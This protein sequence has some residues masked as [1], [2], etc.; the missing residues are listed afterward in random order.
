MKECHDRENAAAANKKVND[1]YP[2]IVRFHENELLSYFDSLNGDYLI[3]RKRKLNAVQTREQALAYIGGARSSFGECLGE[4][5]VGGEVRAD[6]VKSL[7]KGQYRID[8]VL[9]ES[10]PGYYL[11]A[12]FYYPKAAGHAS[13]AIL[14]LCGHSANGK[15]Y[16]TYVSF[17]VEA[18]L[19]GFCVLTFDPVGQ[20][21]RRMY[22]ERDSECF[23]GSPDAVHYLLGQQAWLAGTSIT[24]YMMRDNIAALD[25]LCGR[26]EADRGAISVAGN[27]GGGQM[28][29]FMGACDA[30]IAAVVSSCYITELST[31]IHHIGAQECEQSLWGF[32]ERGLGL[33]DLVIAAAPK[34]YF[35][36]ASLMDFF[37]IEGTRDAY[38][39]ARR[40]YRLLGS[41]GNLEIHIAPKPHGFWWD[42]REKALRFLCN[43][44]GV[45]FIADKGID[46]GSLPTEQELQC[47]ASGDINGFNATSL[48][49]ML[50]EKAGKAVPWPSA[51]RDA[52]GVKS[53][54][55]AIRARLL[56]A[57]KIDVNTIDAEIKEASCRFDETHKL[58]AS[59]YSFCSERY[60][61]IHGTLFAKEQGPKHAA[62]LHVGRLDPGSERLGELLDEYPAVFCVETRGTGRGAVEPGCYF[63]E[64]AHFENEEASY[65]CTAAMLGRSVAGMRT[66][67]VLSAAKLLGG[68]EG[69]DGC[70][71]ALSGVEEDALTALYAAVALGGRDVSL[72]NLLHSLRC[73]VDN[74][75]YLWGA[76]AFPY[77]M[78][79][80]ADIPALLAALSTNTVRIRGFLDHMKRPVRVDALGGI[81]EH[82]SILS[83]IGGGRLELS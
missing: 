66:L 57:L 37:P 77:D 25:Y 73:L 71:V 17:C 61:Q 59:E 24:A 22:D 74:R 45:E 15:A 19:N 1:Y 28:A 34:P 69:F 78:L 16:D 76:S 70:R 58:Y 46:Y 47:L 23:T 4:L 63:F 50:S 30:R 56:E 36:G 21:E 26:S 32:M 54:C 79:R 41:E 42:T 44:F 83:A 52:A 53:Y 14:F 72:A 9:I 3:R 65:C 29:A 51:I 48:Q 6:V 35:I 60:M 82:L 40:V 5:P 13:P 2:D 68:L 75:M 80:F 39:D 8:N 64:P 49:R 55:E 10:L 43:R 12:N 27:S 33:A 38:I 62:M 31:M 18:V 7:D 11:S 67:D 20:G 81:P